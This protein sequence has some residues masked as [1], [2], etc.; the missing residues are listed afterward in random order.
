MSVPLAQYGVSVELDEEG[1]VTNY[2]Q[3]VSAI[4][5]KMKEMLNDE[6]MLKGATE[7][8][9]KAL[10]E[11][12]DKYATNLKLFQDSEADA[13]KAAANTRKMEDELWEAEEEHRKNEL[14]LLLKY[15]KGITEVRQRNLDSL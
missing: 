13:M 9:Q 11:Q 7:E 2:A 10:E 8:E 15:Q 4:Q 14:A 6:G 1:L 5:A 3:I 12:Y